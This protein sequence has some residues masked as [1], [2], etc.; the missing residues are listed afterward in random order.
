M[1]EKIDHKIVNK[2]IGDFKLIKKLP[3]DVLACL[4]E[5]MRNIQEWTLKAGWEATLA[6]SHIG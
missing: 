3:Q 2:K 5:D 6:V 1:L 4:P